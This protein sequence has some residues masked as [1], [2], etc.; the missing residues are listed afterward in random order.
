MNKIANK[1]GLVVE[2]SSNY[3]KETIAHWAKIR[4]IW[5]PWYTDCRST[6]KTL[7]YP[8][9]LMAVSLQSLRPVF[10]KK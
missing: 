9:A 8:L 6:L 1:Y 7:T 4:P 3:P 5:P 10:F 2:F